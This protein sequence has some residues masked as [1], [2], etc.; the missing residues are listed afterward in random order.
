MLIDTHCHLNAEAYSNEKVEEIINS[1]K[2]DNIEKVI[3]VGYDKESSIKCLELSNKYDSVYCAIGVHP[4]NLTDDLDFL[5]TLGNG[6]KVVAIGEIGLDYHY[7]KDKKLEQ[8][9]MFIKQMKIA[10]RLKKPIVI[11]LRDAYD[12]MLR[13]LKENKDLIE[14]GFVVHCFSGS[15]EV[16]K[17]LLKLGAYLSFTGVITFANANRTLDVIREI[18]LDKIMVETDCPYLTPV[19]FRGKLNEPKYVNYV[20]NKICE[21]KEKTG[22]ELDKIIRENTRKFYKI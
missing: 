11:H 17:E 1:F 12:D 8:Q 2:D 21:I 19:P 20:F 9:E 6:K 7:S 5:E 16:A 22:N 18:P 14:Y 10:H 4:E 15:V 13:I 3:T